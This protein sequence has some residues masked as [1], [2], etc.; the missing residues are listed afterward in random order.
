MKVCLVRAVYE[1]GSCGP[2]NGQFALQKALRICALKR[3][4]DWFA[5]ADSALPDAIPWIWSWED[6]DLAAEWSRASRPFIQGPNTLFINSRQPRCDDIEST[7][8]DSASCVLFFTESE[9][10]RRLIIRNRAA[11]ADYPIVLWPYPID[12]RPPAPTACA[13]HDLLIYDKN[14][15]RPGLCE[16]LAER[17]PRSVVFHYGQFERADLWSAASASRSCAYLA[18]DDRGPLALAEILMCGCPT[19]GLPTGAPFVADGISGRIVSRFDLDEFTMAIRQ[20]HALDRLEIARQAQLNFD[21]GR[22]ADLVLRA[23]EVN[24]AVG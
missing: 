10:Y 22:I 19:V 6:R 5:I 8:L 1:P 4:L 3:R 21:P 13:A 2:I 23:I 17:F 24:L 9:W 15:Y 14:G 11:T 16:A 12:P 18:D 20:C 7:L